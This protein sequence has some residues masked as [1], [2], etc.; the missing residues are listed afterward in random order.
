[1]DIE[2]RIRKDYE[3]GKFSNHSRSL[4][5]Y[6]KKN[7]DID[8]YASRKL[9][10][11]P[12]YNTKGKVLICLVEPGKELRKCM[13]CG[14][15][16][17]YE[18]NKNKHFN[19]AFCSRECAMTE[20]GKRIQVERF[21]A[22]NP[23]NPMQREDGKAAFKDSFK[24]KYG[25]TNPSLV[26]E[27]VERRKRTCEERFGA[28]NVFKTDEFKVFLS[29]KR[30]RDMLDNL[31][32]KLIE[33]DMTLLTGEESIFEARR[34]ESPVLR[35]KCSKCG[36]VFE[37]TLFNYYTINCP[38]C[39]KHTSR[40]EGEVQAF[41]ESLGFSVERG[42][43]TLLDG[44]EV[45]LLIPEKRIGFEYNG[46]YW[47]SEACGRGRDY[48]LQKSAA[49]ME[50][51]IRLIHIFE[52]EWIYKRDIVEG[53]VRSLLGKNE[54]RI[55]GRKCIVKEIGRKDADEFL[56]SCHIQGKCVSEVN[57]GLY[58]EGKL[59]SVMTFGKP[60]FDKTH[61][62]ELLRFATMPNYTVT[63]GA[64]KLLTAF[65][66]IHKNEGIIS[67]ADRRWSNGALYEA[68]GFR[69]LRE[70]SPS[71]WYVKNDMRFHRTRFQKHKLQGQLAVYDAGL[72]EYENMLNNGYGRIWDCGNKVY[73][74]L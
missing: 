40:G 37:Y 52:D 13:V 2:D 35:C 20:D 32:A 3:N 18:L 26:N 50:A 67:Y 38:G 55:H 31:K 53:R 24:K 73:E 56:D 22:K 63:G 15:F 57:M 23:V 62:W 1:M 11:T 27:F 54:Y 28:D 51:G 45:D 17:D 10:E 12:Q 47:H 43:R 34:G 46:L 71:Y 58:Y 21:K 25:V 5:S 60:R 49:A 68:L 61:R 16:I 33:N 48:H 6:L 36:T 8:E 74:L 64:G 39:N 29:N 30:R 41:I 7:P 14:R 69:L 59:L 66:R 70:S 9:E 19:A 44:M 72:S 65:R 4:V 42:N